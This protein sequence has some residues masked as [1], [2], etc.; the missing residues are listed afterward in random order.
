MAWSPVLTF[1]SQLMHMCARCYVLCI[2][3][4]Q[5]TWPLSYECVLYWMATD[6][7]T[8]MCTCIHMHMHKYTHT[9]SHTQTHITHKH[10]SLS[11]TSHT[12]THLTHTRARTHTHTHTHTHT[13]MHAHTCTIGICTARSYLFIC[14]KNTF[15]WGV[16]SC[17]LSL[18]SHAVL[19]W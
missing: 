13:C 6:K 11:H 15:W 8:L 19:I 1:D 9:P 14:T 7:C 5:G 18:F 16:V 17:F 4:L 12:Q 3:G 10:T 2:R